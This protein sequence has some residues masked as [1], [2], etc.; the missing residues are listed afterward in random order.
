MNQLKRG[1]FIAVALLLL[2]LPTLAQG[3]GSALIRFV[4]AIPGASAIDIY[5]DGQ[6][7]I[8]ALDYGNASNY[9]QLTPGAHHLAVKQNGS[10]TSLWEQDINPTA[11][12]ASTLVAS[13][14]AQ[15]AFTVYQD[16]LNALPLGKT[17][18]TAIDAISD[19]GN[20][21]IL[22][23]DGRPV[24]PGLQYNQPYGTLDL[25]AMS[26][27][28]VVVPAGEAVGAA[29]VTAQPYN[30]NT[31]TYYVVLAYGTKAA[32]KAM[33]LSTPTMPSADGGYVRVANTIPGTPDFD[34]F[35]N[36]TIIAPS[37]A[38]GSA[39]DYLALP[40]GSYTVSARTPG[41]TSDLVTGSLTVAN[42]QYQ[43]E[44]INGNSEAITF[45][46]VS[47]NVSAVNATTSALMLI[48][49]T[50]DATIAASTSDGQALVSNITATTFDSAVLQP[51]TSGI[52]VDVTA[53][54][55]T[56]NQ[57][58]DL[59]GGVYGGNYYS[60][61]AV[62]SSGGDHQVIQL[63][64]VSLAQGAASA[65]GAQAA[66]TPQATPEVTEAPTQVAQVPTPTV[67]TPPTEAAAQPTPTPN[68]E[69]QAQ[70]TAAPTTTGPTA[71][72]LL[73]PGV[74]LQLRQYPDRTAF[75]LGLAPSGATLAVNGRAGAPVPPPDTTATPTPAG[76]TPAFVDP[77]TLLQDGQDLN[78][79]DTWVNVTYSTPD[80]GTITAWVNALYLSIFDAKGRPMQ[81]RDLPT[82]PSNRAGIAQN[83]SI[84]PPT[85]KQNVTY[86]IV[87][88]VNSDVRVHIRRTPD[89]AG[90]SL[91]LV[92]AGTQLTLVGPDEQQD[93][94][95]VSYSD[96]QSTVTG[97][98]NMQFITLQRNGQSVTFDRLQEL[99][100]LKVVGDDQRGSVVNTGPTI[101]PA[102]TQPRNVVIGTVIG[103]NSDSNL[104][105]R[106]S[107]S[108]QGESLALLPN[109]TTFIVDGRTE[110][111]LWLHVSY[112]D[113]DGWVSAG[114]VALTFNGQKF[115][116]A[117]LPDL[118]TATP[119]ATPTAAA[120]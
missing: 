103:L 115:E 66:A 80:G 72:V 82:V 95:F 113:Q 4:H 109:G 73:D 37:L 16:D 44:L 114:Y 107:A 40:A 59:P 75:S 42:N 69:I 93:W 83:T 108:D 33:L 105:L 7:T 39:T 38:F 67:N 85:A 46:N 22:L 60:A 64:S 29:L 87:T 18:F 47:D 54:G 84:Q 10:S 15:A 27:N 102:A 32:P 49:E 96:T 17:R 119:T 51:S 14:A 101:Q 63:P 117:T 111:S 92:P 56:N 6:L 48:N 28:L 8:S 30:L 62:N 79:A 88:N 12:S 110:D 36:N 53:D 19:A 81:L 43:T 50:S 71:R 77:V 45:V 58:L 74:N 9:V 65:P 61:V 1:L 25:P 26:Y 21:D 76:A 52:S 23:A 34:V 31:E 97:W 3:S 70:P 68:V 99:N 13:S 20:L 5:T 35:I 2:A 120:G 57:A 86:A 98:V 116:L 41:G 55:T 118:S 90:E 89:D 106:R 24:I 104:H 100:E 78:P 11:N 112:Q 94:V 91:A